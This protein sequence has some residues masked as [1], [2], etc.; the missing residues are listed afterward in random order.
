MVSHDMATY[1]SDP[2]PTTNNGLREDFGLS[3]ITEH[4]SSNGFDHVIFAKE[5]LPNLNLDV[6]L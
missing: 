4:R 6:A 3:P 1:A 5:R 2:K